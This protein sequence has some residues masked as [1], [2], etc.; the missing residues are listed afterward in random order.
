MKRMPLT[1]WQ[2]NQK[3]FST[4]AHLNTITT[5]VFDLDMIKE[6]YKNLPGRI[7]KAARL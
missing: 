2:I 3:N 5:M 4:L 6:V 7:A 1:N